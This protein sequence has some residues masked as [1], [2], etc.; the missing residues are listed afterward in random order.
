MSD[1]TP[2]RLRELAY[3]GRVL[4]FLDRTIEG[5]L[6]RKELLSLA[7]TLEGQQTELATLRRAKLENASLKKNRDYWYGIA[8]HAGATLV[9]PKGYP[10]EPCLPDDDGDCQ[11]HGF[12]LAQQAKRITEL[13]AKVDF[14]MQGVTDAT[15]ETQLENRALRQQIAT[16]EYEAA[17]QHEVAEV[18]RKADVATLTRERDEWKQ[19]CADGHSAMVARLRSENER[20]QAQ[21]DAEVKVSGMRLEENERLKGEVV[22][23]KTSHALSIKQYREDVSNLREKLAQAEKELDEAQQCKELL[24]GEAEMDWIAFH[25]ALSQLLDDIADEVSGAGA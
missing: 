4:N 25:K 22:V 2:E 12:L 7:D 14:W 20:L 18:R 16:L 5:T 1:L 13:E 17:H 24:A 9:P 21:Y 6:T 8:Q 11:I 19:A 23:E 15:K 3:Q 10:N